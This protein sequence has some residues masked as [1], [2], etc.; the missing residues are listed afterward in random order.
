MA[1]NSARRGAIKKTGKG[2]PTAGSGGRVRR[3]LEGKG[4]TPK[5]FEREGHKAY[6][7]RQKADRVASSRPKKRGGGAAEWVAG[8]NSVVEVLR[9]RMPVTAV[10]VAE[11]AERDPAA[12]D[13]AWSN[14]VFFSNGNYAL[15]H[16]GIPSITVAMGVMR[17]I[18][19]P[20]G[21]TIAGRGYD[22][23]A[24]LG[25][26]AAFEAGDG[27]TLRRPPFAG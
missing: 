26:A 23:A 22:D 6:K 2:N 4:P 3:A 14:G 9:A 20:V 17:D 12:A 8:R 19:M 1:G 16:L 5:A 10:Y 7:M 13:H 24:L 21:L 18:G 27:G 15:R 11:N 25:Y